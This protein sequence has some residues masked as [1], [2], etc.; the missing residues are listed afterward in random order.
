MSTN[1]IGW[2]VY[3]ATAHPAT[4]DNT[5]F[6]ALSWTKVNGIQSVGERGISH[7]GIDVP[8]LQTG[9]T[10]QV[11]GAASGI[12][13]NLVFRDVDSDTGQGSVKTQAEDADGTASI[14]LVKGTGTDQAPQA[15]DVVHYAQGILHSYRPREKS[16]TS[17][18]GF[19][20][21]FRNNDL[22]VESTEPV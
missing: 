8:D 5:G 19:S 6:E 13:T 4:N 3:V 11:K 14:K 16:N 21:I 1:D 20:V 17:H 7:D 18:S 9:F 12:D 10:T 2:T 22:W 15:G